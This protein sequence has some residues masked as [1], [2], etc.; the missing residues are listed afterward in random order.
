MNN[1][2]TKF[3]T[4]AWHNLRNFFHEE[5]AEYKAACMENALSVTKCTT[6]DQLAVKLDQWL[7]AV[8]RMEK[9]KEPVLPDYQF[10]IFKQ[11]MPKNLEDIIETNHHDYGSYGDALRYVQEQLR[12]HQ[13]RATPT[14]MDIGNLDQNNDNG[15]HQQQKHK[16]RRRTT[17]QRQRRTKWDV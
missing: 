4:L 16:R 1:G 3:G 7:Y 9:L 17:R 12:K 2:E 15:E 8:A 10:A 11:L 6:M 5:A 13:E 14:P